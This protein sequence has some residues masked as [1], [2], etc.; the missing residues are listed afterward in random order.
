M[1][2]RA[3]FGPTAQE[4]DDAERAGFEATLAGLL[5]PAGADAGA[6]R[7][8]APASAVPALLDKNAT[9]DQRRASRQEERDRVRT[10]TL[11]WLDRMVAADH[12]LTEKLVFFW[13]GHWAT[14]VEKVKV[15]ALMLGQQDVFRRYG[16]GD[17]APFV[18]AMLR[19]PALILW[20]DGQ[21]NTR[22]APN[23]NLSR[24]LMEL[25]TLG[26]GHYTEDDVKEGA[27][28]LTGWVLDRARR[29]V[30]VNA[31]RHDTGTKTILGRTGNL[32]ADGFADIILAQ[33]ANADFL[34]RRLWF[35]FASGGDIPPSTL[36]FLAAA[37]HEGRDITASLRALF[38]DP[39]FAATNGQ[40]V[41]QP[42]EWAVGAMRQLHIRPSGLGQQQQR[43]LLRGLD[44]LGQVPFQPPSVGG[45]PAGGAWLTTSA[46]QFRLRLAQ[47]L[48]AQADP[49]V[50][51]QLTAAPRA[52]RV[53]ALAR[54]LVV[55]AFT[56]RSRTVL[57]AA[58][59]DIRRLI[60]L[61]LASP[62]YTVS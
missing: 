27:R 7:T 51:A 45:W 29:T 12:Q 36:D 28:A 13:H 16:A 40:L 3:T 23:E 53:D 52:Q 2:R 10:A 57:S 56:D 18:K 38:T 50:I 6:A 46:A 54:L 15:A 39:R 58:A 19:D 11:W 1:L 61:G 5:T 33:P 44:A 35:R 43:Q 22:Q 17:F 20:L 41:K 9:A 30:S 14:S 62:E 34:G 60:A 55:D 42:V 25:F 4:V 48:A 37:N 59:K 31:A 8:P 49:S 32:D 26:V 47:N 21:K 24:E